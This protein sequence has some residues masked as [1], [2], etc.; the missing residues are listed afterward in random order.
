M[1]DTTRIGTIT[2][3]HVATKLLALGYDVYTPLVDAGVDL[4]ISTP[5]H[6]L[7]IQVKTA[8]YREPPD[9]WI[10][11]ASRGYNQNSRT[12]LTPDDC[13][14]V[15]TIA[16]DVYYIIPVEA[17]TSAAVSLYPHRIP[18][19]NTYEMYKEAWHLLN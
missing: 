3:M 8:C 5:P 19:Q 13:D 2:E 1:R 9:T 10:I 14:Y 12:I 15:I 18:R 7:R 16:D 11:R 17:L 4:L 6:A